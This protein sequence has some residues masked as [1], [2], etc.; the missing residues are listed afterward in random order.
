MITSFHGLSA[1]NKAT[2]AI[3][4]RTRAEAAMGQEV[5][6][7]DA[8]IGNVGL[9]VSGQCSTVYSSDCWSFVKDGERDTAQ[10]W[11]L[12]RISTPTETQWHEF[13]R[14]QIGTERRAD[15][16]EA[17]VTPQD[18]EYCWYKSTA[19]MTEQ[20]AIKIFAASK[21]VPCIEVSNSTRVF[22]SHN[23]SDL[24]LGVDYPYMDYEVA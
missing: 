7:A 16:C 17:W 12:D 24:D 1:F 18:V 19:S 3:E 6:C 8:P 10:D 2:S 13:A 20:R 9:A 23:A 11:N 21:R 22:E 5:C 14:E 15:Y 4:L